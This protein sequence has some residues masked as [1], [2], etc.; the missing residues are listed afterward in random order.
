M[1]KKYNV[2][3]TTDERQHLE[4]LVSKG[5][6]AARTLSRAWILLNVDAGPDGPAWTDAQI[7]QTFSVGLVT[8]YRIRQSF[9]E[10]GF[11]VA[12]ARKRPCRSRRRKLDGDQ[13][14]HLIALACGS[15]PAG[16]CRWTLRMLAAK[17]V[18]LGHSAGVCPETVRQTL[19]KTN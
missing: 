9:V 8:I 2:T 5:K 16:R 15:P 19:K 3:L 10:D 1:N 12:L 13:E 6:A 14:A 11:Q 4:Q 18:E 17:M 7:H